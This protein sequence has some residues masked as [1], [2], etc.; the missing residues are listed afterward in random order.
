MIDIVTDK[1]TELRKVKQIGSVQEEDRIYLSDEAYR[2]MYENTGEEKNV[3]VLMGHTENSNGK[4]A[5]FVEAAI[6]IGDV[7]F[8]R[9]VP[10]WNNQVWQKVFA[11][12]KNKFEDQIIVGWGLNLKGF[13]PKQTPELEKLH[14]EQFGGIHQILFLMN[15][16]EKEE[17]VFINKNNR[18]YKKSGF[19]VY[20]QAK[21]GK[22]SKGE[23]EKPLVDI[24]I[25]DELM[26]VKHFSGSKGGNYRKLMNQDRM[27]QEKMNQEQMN[28]KIM[29]RIPIEDNKQDEIGGGWTV[30]LVAAIALLVVVVGGN[31]MTSGMFSLNTKTALQTMGQSVVNE[32]TVAGSEMMETT[33]KDEENKKGKKSREKEEQEKQAVVEENTEIPIIPVE[34]Y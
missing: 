23:E 7:E 6:Y 18:L 2:K 17:Y 20:Y 1:E 11:K 19:F 5:T 16:L 29:S 30:G 8:E 28:Q 33:E 21:S 12:V 14:R 25:P 31:A 26:E 27:N 13:P 32:R 34:E 22:Q 3:Y 10:V 4:Y 9:N 24:E 15:S